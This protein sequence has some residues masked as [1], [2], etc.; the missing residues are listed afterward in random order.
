[1]S[2]IVKTVRQQGFRFPYVPLIT[3]SGSG[4]AVVMALGVL[5]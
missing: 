3:L 2:T 5:S 1:M 4:A